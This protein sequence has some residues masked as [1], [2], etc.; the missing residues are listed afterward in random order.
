MSAASTNRIRF[1]LRRP[2][3]L[4][5]AA[6]LLLGLAAVGASL[7]ERDGSENDHLPTAALQHEL[8]ALVSD[9]EVAPGAAASVVSPESSWA[10]AA[11][12]ADLDN[13]RALRPDD[14]FRIA[15]ITKTYVAAV[16]LQLVDE[17]ALRLDEPVAGRLPGVFPPG[18]AAITVRQLLN[19]SSG[20]Y[21][22]MN[23]GVR[24]LGEDANR[25]LASFADEDLRRRLATT[26]ERYRRDPEILVPAS[27]WVEIA[28]ARPLS[29]PPGEGNSYSNTNYIVLG[30]LV[31]RVADAPLG[32]VLRERL[33]EPVGLRDTFYAPGPDLPAP[34][35]HG[36]FLEGRGSNPVDETRVTGGIAGASSIVADA[37]DVSRFFRALLGGSVLPSRLLETMLV[38]HMGIGAMPLSCG[39]AYGHDGGWTGYASYARASRD[40]DRATVLLLNGRGPGTGLAAEVALDKL[41]C[42]PERDV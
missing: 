1:P 34:F 35:A 13:R 24:E 38:E 37:D 27:L 31:E 20:L 3:T 29:F 10:G 4:V 14:R 19:H 41:F 6:I 22:S 8:D 25:F 5:A 7:L 39:V 21:D 18:K 15:S 9:S 26:I 12:I 42:A 16:V 33:F 36:Y 2:W 40:G 17:G 11:G 23:D 28:M 30:D 32:D